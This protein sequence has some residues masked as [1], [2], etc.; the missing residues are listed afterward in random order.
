MK[1]ICAGNEYCTRENHVGAPLMRKVF[2]CEKN[3]KQAVIKIAAVGFYRLFFNG[4]ELTK[5]YFAPYISN[6]DD[7][8]YFDEY[9]VALKETNALCIVLGNGFSN[10]MD[11]GVWDF[12]CAPYR[13]APKVAAEI[14]VG[15]KIILQT[16][17]TF[18]V[19]PSA[20]TFDDVR[21][22]ERFDARL[23]REELFTATCGGDEARHAVLAPSPKGELRRC[24][25]Q[26]VRIIETVA[27]VA[28]LPCG[29]GYVYD[30]GIHG[31][32][33]Y[34]LNVTAHAG[35][36]IDLTF[37]EVLQHGVPDFSNTACG[38]K[39]PKGYVQHD[40][41]I[42]KEGAQEYTPSF[43]YHGFRYIFVRGIEKEQATPSLLTALML[44][45]DAPQTGKFTC[46]DQILCGIEACTIRSNRSN[47][48]VIPT[49]C[50]QR[51]KNG[52]TGD[53]FLSAEQF[54]YHM[55]CGASLREWLLNVRKAQKPSGQLPGIVPTA[56]WGFAWGNGP[57]WD[58][59][60]IE[61][62]YQLYRFYGDVNDVS[63]NICAI[64]RYFEFLKSKRGE[65]GCIAF[66]LGDW[67]ETGTYGEDGY[68]TPNE[69]TDTLLCIE[70]AR[71]AALL[72]DVVQKDVQ[73]L[74]LFREELIAAFRNKYIK[75]GVTTAQTQTAQAM[76]ICC[77]A[78]KEEELPNAHRALREL[79][80]RA[81]GHFKVGVIGAKFLF[82]A[83]T[84]GGNADMAYRAIARND[85]PSF[86]YWLDRGATTL[87]EA[88]NE[89]SEEEGVFVRKD[90]GRI[91]S[92]NHHFWGSVTAWFY[93]TL[94]GI[95]VVNSS[96]VKI[97]PHFVDG[98]GSVCGTFGNGK[99]SV[100]VDWKRCGEA[101]QLTVTNCGYTGAIAPCGYCFEKGGSQTE[102]QEG[103][104]VYVL[105][106]V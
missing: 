51:E 92:L 25:S 54:L 39:S 32:G 95:D 20:I 37:A 71:K 82:D 61:L 48:I 62:T 89:L 44:S 88:F 60:L 22:G 31:A 11:G 6:P 28:V 55:D 57:A 3:W 93:R 38:E 30:F 65:N 23:L 67:C 66:G 90:G 56:G 63:D 8:V 91:L 7:C 18:E 73:D 35:Q 72:C 83:L 81:D 2:S 78:V 12:E 77:G 21:A 41:Y 46:D 98:L 45:N 104:S 40:V 59:V 94:A 86:G 64:L 97:A 26:P 15:G 101:V 36:E 69:V 106:R 4:K 53:T 105:H 24:G 79:V 80:E 70:L 19:Y 96:T 103:R 34:T 84:E 85:F 52:W 100:T 50:P 13:A 42:C 29:D 27:P 47:L 99:C 87:W 16:D 9:E 43:T 58:G 75:G 49:D 1:F 102:L 76:A 10:A 5:G 17:E 68:S 33:V 74:L 14:S